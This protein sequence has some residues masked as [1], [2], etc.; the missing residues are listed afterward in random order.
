MKHEHRYDNHDRTQVANQG[1]TVHGGVHFNNVIHEDNRTTVVAEDP[2]EKKFRVGVEELRSGKRSSAEKL[3]GEAISRGHVTDKTVYYWLLSILSKRLFEQLA[4][5]DVQGLRRASELLPAGAAEPDESDEPDD[6][7]NDDGH[8]LAAAQTII[9][10]VA[11]QAA[12]EPGRNR[13]TCWAD[14]QSRLEGLPPRRASEIGQHLN[15]LMH[16]A[17]RDELEDRE[18]EEIRKNRHFRE[19]AR[20]AP[21]FFIPDPRPLVTR[22]AVP[23]PRNLPRRVALGVTAALPVGGALWGVVLVAGR[24]WPEALL[25]LLLWGAGG[26]ALVMSVPRWAWLRRRRLRMDYEHSPLHAM[27]IDTSGPDAAV[28]ERVEFW[29]EMYTAADVWFRDQLAVGESPEAWRLARIGPQVAVANDLAQRYGPGTSVTPPATGWWS[30]AKQ[31]LRGLGLVV[32]MDPLGPIALEARRRYEVFAAHS[33]GKG[34]KGAP[35]PDPGAFEYHR[36]RQDGMSDRQQALGWLI[37]THARDVA[38]RWRDGTLL[39][40]RKTLR[41]TIPLRL[42]FAA[43]LVAVAGAAVRTVGALAIEHLWP[44]LGIV[45]LLTAGTWLTWRCGYPLARAHFDYGADRERLAAQGAAE[46]AAHEAWVAYLAERPSDA[47]MATWLDYD[48][49]ALRMAALDNY[50]LTNWEVINTFFLLEAHEDCK[51]ARVRNGPPRYSAYWVRL[52]I[53]T[54]DGVWY[55]MWPLDFLEGREGDRYDE[56]FRYEVIAR[57]RVLEAGFYHADGR[58][59]LVDLDGDGSLSTASARGQRQRDLILSQTMQLELMHGE[60]IEVRID[61][62]D[63]YLDSREDAEALLDIAMEVSGA[64]DAVRILQAV[65]GGGKDWFA[66]QRERSRYR[67]AELAPRDPALPPSPRR[68]QLAAAEQAPDGDPEG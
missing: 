6:P 18:R 32:G 12:D 9:D 67:L 3:I 66:R 51:R 17:L 57:C 45:A 8:Y 16:R 21:L 41:P 42:L 4:P 43:G 61:N 11:C 34:G 58:R 20:R 50:G 10:L 49:R 19:R 35:A 38:T 54:E 59:P 60:K 56:T 46:G 7:D 37:E 63:R 40:F 33:G 22:V 39:D 23:P 14:V 30:R 62:F 31:G 1:G 68:P 29:Q 44:L 53:L 5:A 65:G 27:Q 25:V 26:C 64:T 28:Q 55:N 2:P 13:S 24:S 52:F 15:M 48:Q 47:E 36:L